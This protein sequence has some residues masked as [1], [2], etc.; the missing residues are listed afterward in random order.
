MPRGWDLR[1]SPLQSFSE[2]VQAVQFQ[3]DSFAAAIVF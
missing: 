1:L 3:E 2:R